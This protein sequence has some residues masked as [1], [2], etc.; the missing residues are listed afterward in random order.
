MT[1]G[2]LGTSS[3]TL[4][5]YLYQLAFGSEEGATPAFGYADAVRLTIMFGAA[6]LF[7][8]VQALRR[9]RA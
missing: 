1:N 5:V 6:V 8:A 2:R 3:Q 7:V 9:E 4:G